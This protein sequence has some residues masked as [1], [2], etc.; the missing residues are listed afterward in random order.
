MTLLSDLKER[1]DAALV[2]GDFGEALHWYARMVAAAPRDTHARLRLADCLLSLGKVRE[3]AMVYTALA[4]HAMHGGH[5]LTALVALK[6]LATLE[7]Q[8]EALLDGLAQLY[9]MDSDRVGVGSRHSLVDHREEADQGQDVPSWEDPAL[10]EVAAKLGSNTD[11][12]AESY[13]DRLPPIPLLSQLTGSAFSAVIRALE[14]VRVSDGAQIIEQGC[15]GE[16]LF[17]LARG[18]VTVE[19]DRQDGTR[20]SLVR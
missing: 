6:V 18:T 12:V 1:A 14:L 17:I 20:I 2:Q 19:Q 15:V 4:R 3:A 9:A 13:P 16:A 8:L 7:P 11:A 5:P 10:I